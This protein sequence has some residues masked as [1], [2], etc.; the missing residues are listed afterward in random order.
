MLECILSIKRSCN[1]QR[2]RFQ[3]SQDKKSPRGR[4]TGKSQSKTQDSVS[5]PFDGATS[6]DASA[7]RFTASLCGC[8]PGRE[9]G[10]RQ[11][12][13]DREPMATHLRGTLCLVSGTRHLSVAGGARPACWE[14]VVKRFRDGM[15]FHRWG[16]RLD[17]VGRSAARWAT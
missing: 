6:R 3:K 13:V 16:E 1:G 5:G 17:V 12:I 15:E 9:F 14:K 2:C 4:E 7:R 11:L 8:S 10:D